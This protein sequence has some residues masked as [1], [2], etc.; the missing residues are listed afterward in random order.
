MTFTVVWRTDA[1]ER[2]AAIWNDATDRAAVSRTSNAIDAELQKDPFAVGESRQG[3]T[4]I[5]L[6]SPLGI[7]YDVSP[8]DC[9]V[10]VW[11]V[12]ETV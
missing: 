5:W 11:A 9:L 8:D 10:T 7:F 6:P 3:R 4:R 2:L 1:L 12:W